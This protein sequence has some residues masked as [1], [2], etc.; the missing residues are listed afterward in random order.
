MI[1]GG[2]QLATC[3][4]EGLTAAMREGVGLGGGSVVV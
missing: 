3:K 1:L 2:L 4:V